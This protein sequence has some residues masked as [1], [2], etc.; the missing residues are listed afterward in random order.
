VPAGSVRPLSLLR[1]PE[2][3]EGDCIKCYFLFISF[4]QFSVLFPP[5]PNDVVAFRQV[6]SF[7]FSRPQLRRTPFIFRSCVPAEFFISRCSEN[8]PLPPPP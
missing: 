8:P 2:T 6:R 7:F 1:R 4:E 3:W 5:S